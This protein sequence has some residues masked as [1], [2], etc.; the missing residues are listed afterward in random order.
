MNFTG[1]I[2][3]IVMIVV[4]GLGFL[5]V[6]KLEYFVGAQVWPLVLA[7]GVML[8]VATL[9]I[10]PFWVSAVVGIVAG[11]IVWGATELPDQEERV[12]RGLFPANP[13]RHRRQS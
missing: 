13:K 11:S 9:W 2:L 5:W 4:I 3:G 12:R 8:A 7:I 6:I 1:L 10:K